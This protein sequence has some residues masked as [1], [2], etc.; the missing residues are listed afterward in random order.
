LAV[1]SSSLFL[2][3]KVF[4]SLCHFR[5]GVGFFKPKLFP[6]APLPKSCILEELCQGATGV[7]RRRYVTSLWLYVEVIRSCRYCGNVALSFRHVCYC[8]LYACRYRS[9]SVA[10]CVGHSQPFECCTA[11]WA[12]RH[13]RP[14]YRDWCRRRG[15]LRWCLQ[16]TGAER[17]R[18]QRRRRWSADRPSTAGGRSAD[19]P[20][21]SLWWIQ[22]HVHRC[23]RRN[24]KQRLDRRSC[25]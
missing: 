9:G 21:V 14:L 25:K 15:W 8:V 6:S 24:A 2:W 16:R 23:W 19:R 17:W 1:A 7:A 10:C 13:Y 20:S 18:F 12:G 11:L 22:A 4:W 5:F 3:L